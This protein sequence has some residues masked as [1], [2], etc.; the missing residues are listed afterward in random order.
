M[1][2]GGKA[3]RNGRILEERDAIVEKI[4][5]HAEASNWEEEE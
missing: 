5:R 4:R 2:Q 3:N 1:N